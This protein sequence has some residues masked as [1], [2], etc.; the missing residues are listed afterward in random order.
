MIDAVAE[1][2]IC[3]LRGSPDVGLV[4]VTK[5]CWVR[6]PDGSRRWNPLVD[7]YWHAKILTGPEKGSEVRVDSWLLY[8]ASLLELLALEAD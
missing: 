7:T 8:R 2:D 1:G 6:L 4:E 3:R 5:D